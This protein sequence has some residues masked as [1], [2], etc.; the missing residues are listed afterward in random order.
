MI[1]QRGCLVARMILLVFCVAYTMCGCRYEAICDADVVEDYEFIVVPKETIV[2]RRELK[3]PHGY[4]AE[5]AVEVDLPQKEAYRQ[6]AE[7]VISD[8][9]CASLCPRGPCK[10]CCSS[11]SL[12]SIADRFFNAYLKDA[13]AIRNYN[14]AFE[15]KGSVAWLSNE[16]MSYRVDVQENSYGGGF[17][18]PMYVNSTWSEKHGR[19]L[20]CEDVFNVSDYESIGRLIVQSVMNDKNTT[21]QVRAIMENI[22][23]LDPSEAKPYC[24]AYDKP[25]ELVIENFMLVKGGVVWTYNLGSLGCLDLGIISA[26]V[27][28]NSL[29][30]YLRDVTLSKADDVPEYDSVRARVMLDYHDNYWTLWH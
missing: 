1:I 13:D 12:S 3:G 15:L 20:R 6:F 29:K 21:E 19:I 16:Y 11:S 18:I 9:V 4:K 5:V 8:A 25:G 7:T 2:Y 24:L 27:P 26:F 10:E 30:P 17:G 14:W 22:L 28:Y 23:S